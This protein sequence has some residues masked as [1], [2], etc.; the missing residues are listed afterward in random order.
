MTTE[1]TKK[2]YTD[3]KK[4]S[5]ISLFKSVEFTFRSFEIEICDLFGIW[6]L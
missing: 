1:I 5:L 4:I 2:D 3:F 6:N